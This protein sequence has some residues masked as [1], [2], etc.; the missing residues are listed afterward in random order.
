MV[1]TRELS[2]KVSKNIWG[3]DEYFEIGVDI[4]VLTKQDEVLAG[5]LK[6]INV[7]NIVIE[8]YDNDTIIYFKDIEKI[9]HTELLFGRDIKEIN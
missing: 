2:L 1:I 8:K 3:S 9:I 4:T 7:D 6:D 5:R